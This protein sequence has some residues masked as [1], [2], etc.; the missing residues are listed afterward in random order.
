MLNFEKIL[1][2]YNKSKND[3][4]E[5]I[6]KAMRKDGIYNATFNQS[7]IDNTKNTFNV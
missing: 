4:D 1:S 5:N 2:F 7:V 3:T 6:L